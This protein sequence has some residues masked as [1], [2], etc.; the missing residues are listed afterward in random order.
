MNQNSVL[1]V[2][3]SITREAPHKFL[4]HTTSSAVAVSVVPSSGF[5]VAGLTSSVNLGIAFLQSGFFL[6]N[7]TV[8]TG[9]TV[10]YT[11]PDYASYLA[12]FDQFRIAKVRVRAYF[13][14]TISNVTGTTTS[15]PLIY[16]AI[17]FDGGLPPGTTPGTLLT[18]SNG[19]IHQPNTLGTPFLD[20]VLVPAVLQSSSQ[21]AAPGIFIDT[22]APGPSNAWFG[23][24]LQLDVM[25]ATSGVSMGDI[26]FVVS[27]EYEYKNP[28]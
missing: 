8:G 4:K 12:I 2:P 14:N 19:M 5:V 26:V 25:A 10:P 6:Y 13:S 16:S 24:L 1:G 18:Y 28:R 17:D 3:V 7:P 21:I 15:M 27:E 23:M 22:N 11:Y 20:R 9:T